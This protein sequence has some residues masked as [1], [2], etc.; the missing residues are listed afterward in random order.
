MAY[1]GLSFGSSGSDHSSLE[2]EKREVD[3]MQAQVAKNEAGFYIAL[4]R[5]EETMGQ[6]RVRF[7]EKP[8]GLYWNGAAYISDKRKAL[9]FDSEDKAIGRLTAD[10]ALINQWIK[11]NPLPEK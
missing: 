2:A 6:G 8:S 5:I 4:M 9:F 3:K 11:E 1:G 7:R 10:G